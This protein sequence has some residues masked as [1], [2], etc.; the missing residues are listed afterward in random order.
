MENED[1][2]VSTFKSSIGSEYYGGAREWDANQ[3]HFHTP[4]EHTIDGKRKCMEMHI[5]HY[6][7]PNSF[8]STPTLGTD[9]FASVIA[10]L[11]TSNK[12]E[13]SELSNAG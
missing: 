1:A 6:P 8:A 5:V 7:D 12:D 3:V 2:D 4:S 11:F 9:I 10:V 13:A